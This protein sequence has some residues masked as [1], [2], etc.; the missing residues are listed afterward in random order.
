M[1]LNDL[2]GQ[3]FG[4]LTVIEKR[5]HPKFTSAYWWCR[6]ECGTEK[7]VMGVSLTRGE[8]KSCGCFRKECAPKGEKSHHWRGGRSQRK[9]GYIS[10]YHEGKHRPE[11]IVVMEKHLGRELFEGENVHHKNGQRADNRIENLELWSISQPSGQRIEDKIAWAVSFL[12]QYGYNI[13][14]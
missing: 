7:L 11:H 1:R 6:C 12:Q 10:I 9:D 5:K 3:T 4:R 8:T 2:S 14:L 13:T